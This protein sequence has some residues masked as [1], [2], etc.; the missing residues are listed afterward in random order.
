[1]DYIF[2]YLEFLVQYIAMFL[3]QRYVFLERGVNYL[4]VLF[5]RDSVCVCNARVWSEYRT[6]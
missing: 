6:C 3:I 2:L 4:C 5:V 1:M